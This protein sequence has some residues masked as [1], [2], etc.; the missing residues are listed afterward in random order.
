MDMLLKLV[1]FAFCFILLISFV[2]EYRKEFALPVSVCAGVLF[3]YYILGETDGIFRKVREIAETVGVDILYM[4]IIFKIIGISYIC[5]FA[6][7]VCRDS[8]QTAFS[9]KIDLAGKLLI[10]SASL[11]IFTE[12]IQVITK[13]LP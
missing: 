12:L 5:E 8:G 1:G 3:F 11:P 2:K 13:I 9:V 7:A 10:L 6:S 4:E